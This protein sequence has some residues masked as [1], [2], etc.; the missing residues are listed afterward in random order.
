MYCSNCGKEIDNNAEV[1]IH[2][3]C[4]QNKVNKYCTNCGAEINE[5]AEICVKCGCKI[6]K[7]NVDD[8]LAGFSGGTRQKLVAALLA[9]FLGV[10]GVHDFYLGYNK[11]GIIKLVCTLTGIGALITSVWAII[12]LVK[13]LTGS[14]LDADGNPLV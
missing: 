10:F 7:N 13:I 4:K 6:K 1:C 8:V 2:C 3:G 11:N 9:F 12:D 5:N 14:K